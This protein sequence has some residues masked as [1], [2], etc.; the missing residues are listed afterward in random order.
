[1]RNA[2]TFPCIIA[3][4]LADRLTSP[5]VSMASRAISSLRSNTKARR[6]QKPRSGPLHDLWVRV[7][8]KGHQ[9]TDA[10]REVY[11]KWVEE[12]ARDG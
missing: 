10:L 11:V 3:A 4:V 2:V 5:S 1:M 7:F 9:P 8:Y 6:R 12:M